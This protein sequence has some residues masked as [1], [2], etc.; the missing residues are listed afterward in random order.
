M[1]PMGDGQFPGNYPRI[2][3]PIANGTEIWEERPM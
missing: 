3:S 1:N 2:Q